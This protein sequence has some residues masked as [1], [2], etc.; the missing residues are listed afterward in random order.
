LSNI[1][2]TLTPAYHWS[3][4]TMF[5]RNKALWGAFVIETP[6]GIVYF[7]ADTGY[8]DGEIFR[9]IRRRFGIPRL[10]ILPIGAYEPRWFM[11]PQH[12]NPEEAVQAHLDLESAMTAAIH[13]ET[14]QL[15]DEAID[16]PRRDLTKAL[17]NRGIDPVRFMCPEVGEALRI[18]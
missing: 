7:G 1:G 17:H 10:S 6:A 18:S 16:A 4:R 8:V 3:K 9:D 5:D 15:T 2:F 12:M 13:H 14:I 11:R